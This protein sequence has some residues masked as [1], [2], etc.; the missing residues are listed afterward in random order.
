MRILDQLSKLIVVT[1][2]LVKQYFY[3]LQSPKKAASFFTEMYIKAIDSKPTTLPNG[4]G[5]KRKNLEELFPGIAFKNISVYAK[6]DSLFDN[7]Y[8]PNNSSL[9]ST[10][11][12][13]TLT[14]LV[15]YLSPNRIFEFGS[16]K[17]WTLANLVENAEIKTQIFSL[18]I[19]SRD[20][21]DSKIESIL[22]NKNVTK[23]IADSA[24]FDFTPFLKSIDYIFIDACHS[25]E[26]VRKDSENAFKMLTPNGLIIWHDFNLAHPGVY[27]Y[28]TELSKSKTIYSIK[29][30]ALVI[31]SQRDNDLR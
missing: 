19:L 25:E 26:S 21:E 15:K 2:Y 23:F 4:K 10:K 11:E 30:T 5:L 1:A 14:A 7:S 28:L 9:V 8:S 13:F 22:N 17:G 12:I 3:I 29:N 27:K 31:Y 16:F 20:A 24:V 18:D 6:F